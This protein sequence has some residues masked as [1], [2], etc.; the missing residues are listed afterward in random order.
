MIWQALA[1][2]T[3]NVLFWFGSEKQPQKYE[4]SY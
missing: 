1:G 4:N 3:L 2:T